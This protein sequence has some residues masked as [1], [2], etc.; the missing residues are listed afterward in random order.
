MKKLL[1]IC[2]SIL[3]VLILVMSF[4]IV[5]KNG[6]NIKEAITVNGDNVAIKTVD[7][8]SASPSNQLP[9]CSNT[10]DVFYKHKVSYG[11]NKLIIGMESA[12]IL[13][14]ENIDYQ[15][16]KAPN[17]NTALLEEITCSNYSI[18]LI[19]G[20][21]FKLVLENVEPNDVYY[22][23]VYKPSNLVS[24]L[25]DSLIKATTITM[26]SVYDHV[27][28]LDQVGVDAD[29]LIINANV[30]VNQLNSMPGVS[31]AIFTNET[32]YQFY[33]DNHPDEFSSPTTETE[34]VNMI[35]MVNASLT[36]SG[37]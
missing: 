11:D 14:S 31:G 21:S 13:L 1:I 19:T 7:Y 36:L 30:T 28:V 3:P 34:L 10:E 16:L 17:G 6:N 15:I 20:G 23:R 24:V 22:L 29:N 9:F 35:N 37:I 27:L 8:R 5:D 12:S 2:A 33:I 18:P 25:L 32:D 26:N 4:L